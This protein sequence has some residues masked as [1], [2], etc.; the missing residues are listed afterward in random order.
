M[1]AVKSLIIFV[2]LAAILTLFVIVQGKGIHH[3]MN[4]CSQVVLILKWTLNV[5]G[6]DPHYSQTCYW[7][8][9]QRILSGGRQKCPLPYT[10][11]L[12]SRG[13]CILGWNQYQCCRYR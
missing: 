10:T 1:S 5:P 6:H 13:N 11:A 8:K 12:A 4:I 9:C 2:G 7:T 3:D